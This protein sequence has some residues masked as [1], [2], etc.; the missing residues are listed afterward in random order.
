M[1]GLVFTPLIA[2]TVRAAVLLERELDYVA[3]AR[4]RG[5]RAPYIMFVEILPNVFAP[6]MVEFTVRLGVRDLRGR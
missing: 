2:R 3:A 1:I 6:I 5:E 4:L